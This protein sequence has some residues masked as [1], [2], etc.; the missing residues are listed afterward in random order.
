M[1]DFTCFHI[2]CA[3]NTGRKSRFKVDFSDCLGRPQK[4]LI[5]PLFAHPWARVFRVSLL[6]YLF[7][8]KVHQNHEKLKLL[9]MVVIAAMYK[10]VINLLSSFEKIKVRCCHPSHH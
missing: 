6:L 8:W 5:G 10:N 1:N 4:T 7:K 2:S 9:D 3:N